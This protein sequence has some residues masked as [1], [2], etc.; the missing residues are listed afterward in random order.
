MKLHHAESLLECCILLSCIHC[1]SHFINYEQL[2]EHVVSAHSEE[3]IRSVGILE[4]VDGSKALVPVKAEDGIQNDTYVV[5]T[6]KQEVTS[7]SGISNHVLTHNVSK[8][9]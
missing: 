4:Q 1:G 2:W 8:I 5:G 7:S 6:S 9:K 3:F